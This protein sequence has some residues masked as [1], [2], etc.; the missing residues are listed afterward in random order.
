V[1]DGDDVL[2]EKRRGVIEFLFIHSR[3]ACYGKS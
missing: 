3:I 2:N 1:V